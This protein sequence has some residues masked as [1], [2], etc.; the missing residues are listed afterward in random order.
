[1][2]IGWGKAAATTLVEGP[3]WRLKTTTALQDGVTVRTSGSSRYPIRPAGY[4][5]LQPRRISPRI[6]RARSLIGSS[7]SGAT[8][9]AASWSPPI[10]HSASSWATRA[11][12]RS[13]RRD[14]AHRFPA[15][16]P[17]GLVIGFGLNDAESR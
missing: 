11:S 6:C 9:T 5:L 4:L 15:R 7:V 8:R 10:R 16:L 12:Q 3:M 13:R 14:F 17:Y 1:S 2:A